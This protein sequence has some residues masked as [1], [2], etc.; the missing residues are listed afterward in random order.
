MQENE[1]ARLADEVE[2]E[3]AEVQAKSETLQKERAD[4]VAFVG[5]AGD[6][7]ERE[8]EVGRALMQT[9]RDLQ[10]EIACLRHRGSGKT[11]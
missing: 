10:L 4:M 9:C 5:R 3:G 7:L 11:V 1:I 2:A 6:E 8:R